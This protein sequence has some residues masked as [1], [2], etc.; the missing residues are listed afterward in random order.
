MTDC[1]TDPAALPVDASERIYRS[2]LCLLAARVLLALVVISLV[3]FLFQWSSA[4]RRDAVTAPQGQRVPDDWKVVIPEYAGTG[5]GSSVTAL[6]P[7]KFGTMQE[8]PVA[9]ALCIAAAVLAA[10]A[11]VGCTLYAGRLK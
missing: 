5:R 7:W 9:V 4:V 2:L 1:Y 6:R 8:H 3:L 10:A 11:F